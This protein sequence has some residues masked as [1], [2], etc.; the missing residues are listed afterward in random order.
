MANGEPK[1]PEVK[2]KLVGEDGNAY[3]I[4]GRVSRAMHQAKLTNAQIEEF[5]DKATS[6]NY[7]NLLITVMEFVSVDVDDEE[8]DDE[9][10]WGD[11]EEEEDD[12][13]WGYIDEHTQ[14]YID[15]EEEE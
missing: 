15:K 5:T 2:V 1:Y 4:M 12:G 9:P 10:I 13:S 7:D 3:A 11:L 14:G 6:G 8:Q